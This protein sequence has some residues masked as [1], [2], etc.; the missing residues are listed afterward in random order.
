MAGP[1]PSSNR[2]CG[3]CQGRSPAAAS[4]HLCTPVHFPHKICKA[5]FFFKKNNFCLITSLTSTRMFCLSVTWMSSILKGIFKNILLKVPFFMGNR[6]FSHFES[7]ASLSQVG[8]WHSGL[9]GG[10]YEMEATPT[11]ELHSPWVSCFFFKKN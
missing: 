11:M 6:W 5:N 8:T 2:S 3:G 7:G 9:V 4:P 10:E 1:W